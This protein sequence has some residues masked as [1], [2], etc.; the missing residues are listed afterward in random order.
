VLASANEPRHVDAADPLQSYLLG[1]GWYGVEAN[2]R[3]TEPRATLKMGGPRAAG[4]KLRITA[5]CRPVQV[6][7]GPVEVRF[8]MDGQALRPAR[9]TSCGVFHE[10]FELPAKAIGKPVVELEL[11]VRPPFHESENGRE[12]GLVFG[13]L[14]IR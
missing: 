5:A 4:E 7:A 3:W 8:A 2:F 14:E 10:E 12:L 9:I 1:A 13:T 6:A 11:N